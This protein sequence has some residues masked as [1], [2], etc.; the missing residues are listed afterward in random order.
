MKFYLSLPKVSFVTAL[1]FLHKFRT[2]GDFIK[3]CVFFFVCFFSLINLQ[4]SW[5]KK[6]WFLFHF[7]NL[8][9]ILFCMIDECQHSK[10]LIKKKQFEEKYYFVIY[11]KVCFTF[12]KKSNLS[13]FKILLLFRLRYVLN[14]IL[15]AKFFSLTY[16]NIKFLSNIS[17][18]FHNDIDFAAL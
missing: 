17:H 15:Q 11:C 4:F 14:L 10:M 8:M 5:M 18:F 13:P 16:S 1:N 3:R 6:L 12:F 9:L 2:V 7:W